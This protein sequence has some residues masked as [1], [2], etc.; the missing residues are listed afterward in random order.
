MTS[1]PSR[2]DLADEERERLLDLVADLQIP[3]APAFTEVRRRADSRRR[4]RHAVV[5]SAAVLVLIVLGAVSFLGSDINVTTGPPTKPA[6]QPEVRSGWVW[7]GNE[8]MVSRDGSPSGY[9]TRVLP[10]AAQL[11]I[12]LGDAATCLSPETCAGSPERFGAREFRQL[13]SSPTDPP[14]LAPATLAAPD[15]PFAD[16][17]IVWVPLATG[18]MH[19]GSSSDATVAGVDGPQHF[20][21]RRNVRAVLDDLDQ[22]DWLDP[23]QRVL[24]MGSGAGGIGAIANYTAVVRHFSDRDVALLVGD[25]PL[26]PTGDVF[27][28]CQASAWISTFGLTR[29]ERWPGDLATGPDA[30]GAAYAYLSRRHPDAEM[31]LIL[32]P[33]DAATRRAYATEIRGCQPST[34]ALSPTTYAVAV[35]EL[36]LEVAQLPGWTVAVTDTPDVLDDALRGDSGRNIA[37][38]D[39]LIDSV[40][41]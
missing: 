3:T 20:V 16:A 30:I 24:L 4:T 28:R 14:A 39:R 2:D 37:E 11:V 31:G 36:A 15:S 13:M 27:R 41:R 19:L 7:N 38:V 1:E 9:A 40:A 32:S 6:S 35:E 21:G 18:D 22:A 34:G 5:G 29:P 12:V 33:D 10:D 23:S 25:A 17:T 8:Q 26:F